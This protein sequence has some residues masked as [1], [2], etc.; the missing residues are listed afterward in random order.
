MKIK[1]VLSAMAAAMVLSCTYFPAVPPTA[2]DT[3]YAASE[4]QTYA[5][6][7][8]KISNKGIDDNGLTYNVFLEIPNDTK[9]TPN[10]SMTVKD[11]GTIDVD[12]D[13]FVTSGWFE[14]DY[15]YEYEQRPNALEMGPISIDFD[16]EQDLSLCSEGGSA[17][18]G[19]IGILTS[20][21]SDVG[22]Y[23]PVSEFN[24][25]ENWENWRP[26][27]D[28]MKTVVIDG[29]EYDIF[30]SDLAGST[31]YTSAKG[32]YQYFSVRKEPRKS[33]TI[34]VSEHF[35]A[36][37]SLGWVVGDLAS[38]NFMVAGW[39][40]VCT[41]KINSLKINA[42]KPVTTATTTT[43]TT[44]STTTSATTSASATQEN[45]TT[46]VPTTTTDIVTDDDKKYVQV[47]NNSDGGRGEIIPPY[48]YYS[49][50]T[51][52]SMYAAEN[53][54]FSA[55][56]DASE[57]SRFYAGIEQPDGL[58]Q[59]HIIGLD[60]TVTADYKFE[61]TYKDSYQLSY[62]LSGKNDYK[63]TDII[64]IENSNDHPLQYNFKDIR[65]S[66]RIP[67][68]LEPTLCKTYTVNG[69]EYD[70]YKDEYDVDGHWISNT[71]ETYIVVRKD[72]EEGPILEG[73]IDFKE[74]IKQID[75]DLI[76]NFEADSVFCVLETDYTYGTLKALKNDII[77]ETDDYPYEIMGDFNFDRVIDSLDL[78][79]A[80]AW[81]IEWADDYTPSLYM[82]LNKDNAFDIA[83]V[84]M[85]KSFLLGKIKSFDKASQK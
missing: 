12:W 11:D 1:R 22:L 34:N 60:N 36:W 63:Y 78:V 20:P 31:Y 64:I 16:A 42:P 25:I 56:T 71:Y 10:G 43:E 24:I 59:Y 46:I 33:G 40:S 5:V 75:E 13:S 28:K 51:N 19:V 77:F 6:D 70:L 49:S 26:T 67:D 55:S 62:N 52:G 45:T 47:V 72:Q 84:V 58:N 18:F 50:T 14:A 29:A 39:E 80:K 54:C 41:T 9:G 68:I 61:N 73:S 3:V 2:I 7:K 15:G 53:G 76:G 37:E 32:F 74:H 23:S 44:T 17:R 82:D 21:K 27:G 69:H 65:S 8:D 79:R 48:I 35:K 83:D 38:V 66:H 4:E 30:R 57:I 81:L 85:L